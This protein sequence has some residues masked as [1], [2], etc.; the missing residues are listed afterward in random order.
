M[1]MRRFEIFFRVVESGGFTRAAEAMS[2]TQP[3]LSAAVRQLEDE[4]GVRLLDRLGREVV[5]TAA[6]RLLHGYAQRIFTLREDALNELRSL[7]DGEGG[8]LQ[9]GG[10]TIPGTYILPRI[11]AEFGARYPQVRVNLQL[12]STHEIV[13]RLR[14]RQLELALTGGWVRD[15][16][17]EAI[18]CFGD[19]LVV[20]VPPGHPWA[21]RT[22]LA[23]SE[24]VAEPLLLRERGS[25]SRN[26]LEARLRE[27]GVEPA[28]ANQV[29]EVGG[30]EAL[31]QGV[32]AGLG[33]AVISR[34]AVAGELGRKELVALRFAGGRLKRR[35][36]L[37]RG[38]GYQLSTAAQYFSDLV[39]ATQA[40]GS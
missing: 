36:Y 24:L 2:L 32:R 15:D 5:P 40:A 12:A 31:K 11:V 6:G 26:A 7:Q 16:T 25:A 14:R 18:P 30:N 10:S 20:I 33:V 22:M 1:D 23:E 21:G 27:Q 28:A 17:I 9:L 35:F 4:L 19:E 13:E 29:A 8:E 39:I 34:L 37:L 38:K 3:T